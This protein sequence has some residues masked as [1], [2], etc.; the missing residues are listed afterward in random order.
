M[1]EY[2]TAYDKLIFKDYKREIGSDG[3]E[4]TNQEV[5]DKQRSVAG[6]LIKNIG[7]NLIKGKSIM[8][9]SLPINIFDTRSLL[10]L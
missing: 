3:I 1:I 5:I 2:E 6:Y 4:F 8:N 7:L 10:E 9:I